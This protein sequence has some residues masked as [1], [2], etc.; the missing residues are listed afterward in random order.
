[1]IFGDL[2]LTILNMSWTASFVILFVLVLRLMLRRAPRVF[3]YML[4]GIPLIRLLCPFSL[5]SILSL[6]PINTQPIS[7]DI[8]YMNTPSV[9]TGIAAVNDAVNAVLPPATPQYSM[10]PLQGWVAIGEVIWALGILALLLYAIIS[11]L[12]LHIRIKDAVRLSENIYISKKTD[13]PFVLGIILP[14][15][16]LPAGLSEAESQYIIEHERTHIRR[17]DNLAKLLGFAVLC[18]NWFNPL[19]WLAFFL[20]TKDM[21]GACDEA[22]LKELGPD[23]KAGYSKTLL[24]LASGKRH[25]GFSPAAFGEGSTKSRIKNILKYKKP[26]VWV[27]PIC[28]ILVIIAAL[29]LLFDPIEGRKA[30]RADMQ[31]VSE[32]FTATRPGGPA[33]SF[34]VFP[35]DV[36]GDKIEE[37]CVFFRD[38][39]NTSCAIRFYKYEGN[40]WEE[41]SELFGLYTDSPLILNRFRDSEGLV[42]LHAQT[43]DH[44]QDSI[45]R[46]R[47]VYG[48]FDA[49]GNIEAFTPWYYHNTDNGE[50]TYFLD[51]LSNEPVSKDEYEAFTKSLLSGA[52]RE[53]IMTFDSEPASQHSQKHL[54]DFPAYDDGHDHD[55]TP[56]V[57]DIMLPRGWTV[58]PDPI[59][60][61][62]LPLHSPIGMYD[63]SGNLMG[64]ISFGTFDRFEGDIDRDY[65]YKTVYPELLLGAHY[66]WYDY[67]PIAL[68]ETGET[69]LASVYVQV[70]PGD[71]T[72]AA[73]WP[74]RK[75]DGILSYDHS[76]EVYAVVQFEEDTVTDDV[77]K[78]IARS[79]SIGYRAKYID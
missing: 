49:Q 1:M 43:I 20:C 30:S 14:K 27:V 28:I 39:E 29:A 71:K 73:K 52:A 40:I 57:M 54:I 75:L 32:L 36:N 79:I 8:L 50:R 78:Q 23:I 48:K 45:A 3:S 33:E 53:Q 19:V 38:T 67:T 70:D 46:L 66:Y 59:D 42:I 12:A 13:I 34:S 35:M 55:I 58:E 24:A 51:L 17:H 61:G 69:A 47:N 77:R 9:D 6:I 56:F 63:E 37:L 72:S 21:E 31:E 74:E 76:M 15:I 60:T 22:V 65:Y 5:R 7:P 18:L 10:N 68:S 25:F 11:S 2:F 64:S 62:S 44:A 4:W 16:Y 26:A 41:V